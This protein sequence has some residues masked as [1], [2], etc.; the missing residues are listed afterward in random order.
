MPLC[1]LLALLLL[2][3]CAANKKDTTVCP[4]YRELRCAADIRC[5]M[6][7]AR[8]CR[9]CECSMD[10][11]QNTSDTQQKAVPPG[12]PTLDGEPQR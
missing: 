5:T 8:A 2:T 6:D 4:E 7:Q 9:V 12:S 11:N 3:A 10:L 1:A